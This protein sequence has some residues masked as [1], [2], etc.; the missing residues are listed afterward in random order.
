M[1]RGARPAPRLIRSPRR[2]AALIRAG[3]VIAYPTEAVFGLG[4]NPRDPVAVARL[5]AI[6]GRPPGKGLILIAADAAQLEP[7]LLRLD[8]PIAAR[9][10]QAWPGPVTWLWPA[11]PGIP[12]WLTG[13]HETLAVR[14]TDHPLAA[15]LCREA[16]PIVST[17]ANLAGEEPART[18]E[19]V[20]ERLGR[21]LDGILAGSVGG[22]ERPSEIRDVM[23]GE[24]VRA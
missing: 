22:R 5:L 15:Q 23:T 18:A 4:C 14:V 16:G 13:D 6:K 10:R 11:R 3:G 9:A 12:Q 21:R 7:Y 19:A 17:S 8:E 24:I 1:S 2:A 20:A